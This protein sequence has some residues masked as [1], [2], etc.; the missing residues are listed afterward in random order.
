MNRWNEELTGGLIQKLHGREN[1]NEFIVQEQLNK[2]EQY[3]ITVLFWIWCLR[4][5][6]KKAR[7]EV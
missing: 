6:M 5:V 2:D 7:V 4:T 1:F 3:K